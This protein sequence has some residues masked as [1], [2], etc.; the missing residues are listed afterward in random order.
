M[1]SANS[2]HD[3]PIC[4]GFDAPVSRM[5]DAK[6][7]A[8]EAGK[9]AERRAGSGTASRLPASGAPQDRDGPFPLAPL[10]FDPARSIRA[11]AV[12]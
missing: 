4:G 7:A 5:I 10:R 1:T 8:Y 2:R 12:A 11:S 6:S 9:D 3:D